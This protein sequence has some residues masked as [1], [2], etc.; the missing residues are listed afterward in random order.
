MKKQ[1]IVFAVCILLT[2]V[3][4]GCSSNKKDSETPKLSEFDEWKSGSSAADLN[5][6][7]VVDEQDFGIW[8]AFQI[9][10]DTEDAQ[11]FNNDRRITFLDYKYYTAYKEWKLSASAIDLNGDRKITIDDFALFLDPTK[12]NFV[13]WLSSENA[14][15]LTKNGSIDEDDYLIA[16]RYIEFVGS[17]HLTNFEWSGNIICFRNSRFGIDDFEQY[18][19][20]LTFSIDKYGVLSCSMPENMKTALGE[21]LTLF[22]LGLN[23]CV[24]TRLSPQIATCDIYVSEY[25]FFV[26]FYLTSVDEGYS[27][28]FD[29]RYS[30]ISTTI[31]FLIEYDK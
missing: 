14:V 5:E 29:M 4:F 24:I 26:S 20:E 6:D 17:F 13:A 1:F 16:A 15:D 7:E 31:S 10:C 3:L 23:S 21:D 9:W 28:S 8:Q 25:G 22:E 19:D 11:D 12:S 18:L 2:A 30:N 27:T